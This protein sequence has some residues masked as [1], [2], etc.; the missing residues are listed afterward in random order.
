MEEVTA[1]TLAS[2]PIVTC[3]PGR[4]GHPA[5]RRMRDRLVSSLIVDALY[6]RAARDGELRPAQ[7]SRS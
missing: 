7:F 2:R 1:E 4:H 5:A 3:A 6:V